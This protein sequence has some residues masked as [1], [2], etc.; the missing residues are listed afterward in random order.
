MSCNPSRVYDLPFIHHPDDGV[1]D[2]I[3][4]DN[5]VEEEKDGGGGETP[6]DSPG[7]DDMI[8]LSPDRN[9]GKG[10]MLAIGSAGMG[11]SAWVDVPKDEEE[12]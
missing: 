7:A 4:S 3:T 9:R 5:G 1:G 2:G 10:P 11:A 8:P 6:L 12:G